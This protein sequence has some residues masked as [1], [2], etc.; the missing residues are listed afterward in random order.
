MHEGQKPYQCDICEKSFTMK[1]DLRRHV[2]TVHNKER[3]FQC[4]QCSKTF[5]Q[6]GSLKTHVSVV[7]NK[8]SFQCSKCSKTFTRKINMKEHVTNVHEG[9]NAITHQNIDH[10]AGEE[11]NIEKYKVGVETNEDE[12]AFEIVIKEEWNQEDSEAILGI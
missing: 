10:S 4:P 11:D 2:A 6:S 5:G 7:H 9:K 3:P 12:G 1:S 8:E